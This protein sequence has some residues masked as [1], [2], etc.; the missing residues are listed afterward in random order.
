MVAITFEL[1]PGL[2]KRIEERVGQAKAQHPR[3]RRN[4]VLQDLVLEGLALTGGP[5]AEYA[6]R[7]LAKRIAM[8]RTASVRGR[9]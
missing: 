4:T 1:A 3:I 2:G 5:E 9:P 7:Q 6:Q 8:R